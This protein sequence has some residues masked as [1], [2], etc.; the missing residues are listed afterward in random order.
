MCT[1]QL[2]LTKRMVQVVVAVFIL[3]DFC[4]VMAS[5]CAKG[6]QKKRKAHTQDP[7]STSEPPVED[8]FLAMP[9][10]FQHEVYFPP[11]SAMESVRA[12]AI[13]TVCQLRSVHWVHSQNYDREVAP[14]ST[15]VIQQY[16]HELGKHDEAHL[17][18]RVVSSSG[19]LTNAMRC[20][21]RRWC[22]R[23]RQR[24]GVSYGELPCRDAPPRSNLKK[25][26][27]EVPFSFF[28]RGLGSQRMFCEGYCD[29]SKA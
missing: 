12:E 6:F 3:S 29:N 7:A 15:A 10:G 25:K 24:W 28:L 22:A 19:G 16:A 8:W 20:T 1:S 21:A 23:F 2:G 18:D 14:S 9:D 11:T 4:L 26:A 13:Q 5:Q 27:G 17:A